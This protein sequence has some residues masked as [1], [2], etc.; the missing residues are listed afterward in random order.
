[1]PERYKNTEKQGWRAKLFPWRQEGVRLHPR[2][3]LWWLQSAGLELTVQRRS[4]GSTIVA[5]H[6]E[7]PSHCDNSLLGNP[8]ASSQ[9]LVTPPLVQLSTELPP[10]HLRASLGSPVSTALHRRE[11][12]GVCKVL[13]HTV[14]DAETLSSQQPTLPPRTGRKKPSPGSTLL[15]GK[16]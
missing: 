14:V 2:E 13:Q 8:R 10:G 15:P 12:H 5:C 9:F 3:F 1:M 4:S 11:D 6:L 16:S 7:P